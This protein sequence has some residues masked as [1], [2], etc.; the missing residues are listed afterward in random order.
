MASSVTEIVAAK[1]LAGCTAVLLLTPVKIVAEGM[2]DGEEITIYEETV[3]E[4]S[5]QV[6]QETHGRVAHLEKSMQSIIFEGYG[7]Y[8]FLLSANTAEARKV[9]YA[10]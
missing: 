10:G 1:T 3:T 2:L 6:V 8:K 5:Y 4:G 7:N 9:G